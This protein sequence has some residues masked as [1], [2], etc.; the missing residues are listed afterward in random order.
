M[1]FLLSLKL[2]RLKFL[3]ENRDRPC[4]AGSGVGPATAT[5]AL[6]FGAQVGL[7]ALLSRLF[8]APPPEPTEI[9]ITECPTCPGCSNWLLGLVGLF[10]F[11]AGV[12]A[13]VLAQAVRGLSSFVTGIIAGGAAAGAATS[14][15]LCG[16]ESPTR[17]IALYA[18]KALPIE[19]QRD[20]QRFALSE[21]PR[22][23]LLESW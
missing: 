21:R 14:A 11:L 16:F 20:E 2:C 8:R 18:V 7:C 13:A 6:A 3:F 5:L 19:D 22:P 23:A 10:C 12:G 1:V 9:E 15:A 4:M 17:V